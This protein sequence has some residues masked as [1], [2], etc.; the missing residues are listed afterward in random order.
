MS[1]KRISARL[2]SKRPDK[3][4]ISQGQNS[5]WIKMS[6]V[7]YIETGTSFLLG[8]DAVTIIIDEELANSLELEGDLV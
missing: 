1:L 5:C 8:R 4:L 6:D 2:D 7:K 3:I